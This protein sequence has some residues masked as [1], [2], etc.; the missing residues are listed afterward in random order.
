MQHPFLAGQ[1]GPVMYKRV[2]MSS[3]E[4]GTLSMIGE[5]PFN[6]P[7]MEKVSKFQQLG[8]LK[9]GFD[10]AGTSTAVKTLEENKKW[11]VAFD[12][13]LAVAQVGSAM[14]LHGLQ[15]SE[16]ELQDLIKECNTDGLKVISDSGGEMTLF[17]GTIDFLEFVAMVRKMND[18]PAS[19][20]IYP[21]DDLKKC[22]EKFARATSLDAKKQIFKTTSWFYG[23][24]TGVK[25]FVK[26]EAQDF[27][28]V[29]DITCIQGGPITQLE[30]DE[31]DRI[32]REAASDCAKSGIHLAAQSDGAKKEACCEY[33]VSKLSYR[34]FLRQVS[35]V[36]YVKE[37][38]K[39]QLQE[40]ISQPEDKEPE[41]ELEQTQEND[42]GGG[43][44]E[45]RHGDTVQSDADAR[46][47]V[48]DLTDRER[49]M[50]TQLKD[51]RAQLAAKDQELAAAKQAEEQRLAAETAERERL[52]AENEQLRAQLARLEG[53]PPQRETDS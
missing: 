37:T 6:Q 50:E 10:R 25:N 14:R 46:D 40:P 5:G 51:T 45:G 22:F 41:L 1:M 38:S 48:S 33:V 42:A 15:P 3:P 34:D 52:A 13:S 24:Q 17:P 19:E 12:G 53:V 4:Y 47:G 7:I 28:G 44:V 18:I 8:L 23:Y 31:M 35:Y 32:M 29:L 27:N 39:S 36:D 30:A 43:S 21:E 26:A 2:V 20:D 11:S 9:L 16:A 49:A